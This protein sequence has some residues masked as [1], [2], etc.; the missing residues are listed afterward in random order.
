MRAVLPIFGVIVRRN[1][2][3]LLISGALYLIA[4]AYLLAP[5]FSSRF[6]EMVDSVA[7]VR[8]VPNTVNYN[9]LLAADS[10]VWAGQVGYRPRIRLD[11][12]I[13]LT[14]IWLI[15]TLTLASVNRE[16]LALGDGRVPL[17]SVLAPERTQG[18]DA[19]MPKARSSG[20]RSVP[21][22]E[23]FLADDVI[24]ARV[25]AS[26]LNWRSNLM[27]A[28]GI[29]MAFVGVGI[30]YVTLPQFLAGDDRWTYLEKGIRPTGVLFFLEAIAWFL[31][32]QYRALI[33]DYKTFHRLSLKRANYLVSL[34]VL[35]TKD[36]TQ[37]QMLW[38]A[39]ALSEDLGGK[40]AAGE[41]TEHIESIK[42]I[43]PN[44]VFALFQS[45]VESLK[46]Q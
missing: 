11:N 33:E 39:S 40:L 1:R 4:V 32:R 15:G 6:T 44:P 8:I 20:N 14:G 17:D 21:N 5:M 23:E 13:L 27:L 24:I 7:R 35:S 45:L 38:A 46:K 36:V 26:S 3:L 41:T 18:S 2:S 25:R 31:L 28:G 30:F 37:A 43:E 12:L 29:I 16:A 19:S 9:F 22:A 42:A 34:K 10:G